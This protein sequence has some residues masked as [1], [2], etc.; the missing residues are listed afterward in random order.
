ML[1]VHAVSAGL[2]R[3]GVVVYKKPFIY[4]LQVDSPNKKNKE[5]YARCQKKPIRKNTTKNIWKS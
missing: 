2:N 4:A 1:R 3:K 5:V